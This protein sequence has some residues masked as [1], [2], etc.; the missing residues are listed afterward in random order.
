MD[1]LANLCAADSTD[2]NSLVV[3]LTREFISIAA[4][5]GD[6]SKI[7]DFVEKRMKQLG[8]YDIARDRLGSVVGFVGPN[9]P[10]TALLFDS[11]MDV[12]AI[13]GDWSVNPVGGEVR[14]G[15]L[16][17]R[18][19]TDMKGALAAS[20]CGVAAAARTGP[21]ERKV[22]VSATVLEETAE[23]GALGEVLDRVRPEMTVICEP[24]SLSIK[25]GQR[26]RVEVIVD[27]IGVPAHAAHPERGRNAIGLAAKAVEAL[28]AMQLK[29]DSQLGGMI[30][31]PTDIK[32]DPYPL[33]SALPIGVSIRFD[34]RI[35]TNDDKASVL[36]EI[37][38]VLDAIDPV[39]FRVR[40]SNDPIT[41]YTGQTVRWERFLAAWNT[42]PATE[43]AQAAAES[44]R[45]AGLEVR[46]GTYA[47]CTNGSESA[48]VRGIPT[49]GLGPGDESQAHIVDESVSILQ[50]NQA[51]DV[52]RNLTLKIAGGKNAG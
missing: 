50:L 48:G 46:F 52:Y 34:R 45:S 33:I 16:F 29:P 3:E 30:L 25:T 15:R 17:G 49:I 8:F 2:E 23:G 19:T 41:T 26:G 43:L 20:L 35:G 36:Q 24:S 7:A 21:L 47:F 51:V 42:G 13:T 38:M 18:G 5:S 37:Q 6:E 9:T 32:S 1:E 31:V 10:T 27:V 4:Q 14:D 28:A 22:A 39:A 40:A 11:H 12:V 44:L